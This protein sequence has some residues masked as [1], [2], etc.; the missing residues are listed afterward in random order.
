[1]SSNTKLLERA[2]ELAEDITNHPSGYDKRIRQLIE[3]N[4]LEELQHVVTKIES[5]L[6][7][8]HFYGYDLAVF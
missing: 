1:M 3:D 8:E 4:N 7:Q 2:Y 5:E 6:A